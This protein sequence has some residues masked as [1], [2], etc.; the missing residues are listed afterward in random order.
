MTASSARLRIA[1]LTHSTN[2]RGGVV[3]ALELADA[4]TRL[5]HVAVVHAPD[6]TGKGFFRSS[7]A[8]TVSVPASAV[9]DDV[10]SMVETRIA[11]YV[12]HFDDPAHRQFDVY[13][14]QD[15]ISGN[16]LA[17]L[18]QRGLIQGY[19]RTVHH[20]DDFRDVRL[21][22]LDQRSI[23]LADQLF[24]V[25]RMWQERLRIELAC[26]ST[27]VGNAVD[28]SR[29]S[30]ASNPIDSA[31][32]PRLG[33][34]EGPVLLAIGGIER[35]KNTH[36]I[37]DAFCQVHAV[38]RSAQ[39][40]IAGGASLL[41]HGAY[42]QQFRLRL[43]DA[44]LP[45]NAVIETGPLADAEMPSLYRLSDAL[46]FPS[47]REGFGLVVLEAMASG[48]PVIV[49]H[50]PPFTE[51]LGDDDVAWCDPHHAGS[52]ANAIIS[53]LSEPL[54]SRLAANGRNVAERHDWSRTAE[55]HLPAY[56]RMSEVHYA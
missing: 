19:V 15:G 11:D 34:R 51:Y 42:Q 38:H 9:S 50:I 36:A 53:A 49:S 8:P 25:S 3:H 44:G 56:H 4:L 45:A 14:A 20:V 54:R 2:A 12:R 39:L 46:A 23:V 7:L 21:R 17:T 47:L 1:I 13:H 41:D 32:R 22:Q 18:K 6:R 40:V 5:G 26:T 35:R 55:A 16:A 27:L 31:L 43:Q 10:T 33:L 30:P 28:T 29:Y 48:V 37:L 24:V 52:I